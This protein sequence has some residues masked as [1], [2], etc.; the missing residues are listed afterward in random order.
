[1]GRSRPVN[2]FGSILFSLFYLKIT[3]FKSRELKKNE[4][5]FIIFKVTLRHT[6]TFM[7]EM[8]R[9]RFASK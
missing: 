2:L 3:A 8:I 4:F 9:L 5:Q 1:M 7:N 6:E